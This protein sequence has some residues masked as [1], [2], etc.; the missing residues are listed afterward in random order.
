[1]RDLTDAE[2]AGTHRN[3]IHRTAQRNSRAAWAMNT[4][5]GINRLMTGRAIST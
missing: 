3:R 5:T 2:A 4:C 1:M